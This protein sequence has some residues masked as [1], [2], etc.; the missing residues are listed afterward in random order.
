MGIEPPRFNQARSNNATSKWVRKYIEE[1]KATLLRITELRAK[2]GDR[3]EDPRFQVIILRWRLIIEL[4]YEA[5]A[6]INKSATTNNKNS[7]R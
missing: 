7:R 1:A 6:A 3:G 2:L 5:L 4:C